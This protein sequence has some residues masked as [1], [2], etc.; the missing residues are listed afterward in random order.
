MALAYQ[1][2]PGMEGISKASAGTRIR[3]VTCSL[4]RVPCS[5][6]HV[7]GDGMLIVNYFFAVTYVV[8]ELYGGMMD[9]KLVVQ[10]TFYS[11]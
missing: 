2:V 8:F 1:V 4:L 11:P 3:G 7:W 5:M 9:V 6:F 10:N